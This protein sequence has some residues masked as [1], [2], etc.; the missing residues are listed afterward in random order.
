M[1]MIKDLESAISLKQQKNPLPTDWPET[2]PVGVDASASDAVA[3]TNDT[4]A[5]ALDQRNTWQ[6]ETTKT[7]A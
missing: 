4:T 5:L 6:F 3:A 2:H 1:Q 7:N